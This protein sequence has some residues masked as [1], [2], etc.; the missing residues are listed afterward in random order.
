[1]TFKYRILTLGTV[2]LLI[3]LA[4]F[5]RQLPLSTSQLAD[6]KLLPSATATVPLPTATATA[7]M[8]P[9]PT[10]MPTETPSPTPMP[11]ATPTPNM[12]NLD[13]RLISEP[14][15]TESICQDDMNI[16][17]RE[18]E[19]LVPIFLYHFVGREEL[20]KEGLSTTRFNVTAQDFDTQLALLHSL[21]YQT[22]TI[23]EVAAALSGTYTLPTR[24]IAI[25]V[26]DG[27][28]EQYDVIFALLQKYNMRATF[29]IPSTYPIG[30]RF[31][32]WEQLQTMVAAGMEIGSH[33][34]KHADLPTLSLEA[35]SQEISTSKLEIEAKLGI[36]VTSI[37]YPFGNYSDSVIEL[38]QAAGYQA[39]VALGPTPRQS[40]AK[41]YALGRV[42]IFGTRTLAD[43]IGWLP[44]RGQGTALCP[45]PPEPPE[46]IRAPSE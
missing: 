10:P 27:W 42:E 24:P 19:I 12:S 16:T 46:V 43:F 35:A 14:E 28:I 44:W 13:A 5:G 1:M 40:N 6:A 17:A 39:A 30:G 33:T 25:T 29:Y 8:L 21:G 26:D 41:R 22:V 37:A 18:G 2:T 11:T 45:L 9:S 36:T 23:G 15:L 4:L 31:V 7:T 32:T 38:T 3:G 34:R 20:E